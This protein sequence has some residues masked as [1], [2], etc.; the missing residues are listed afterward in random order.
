MFHF[1]LTPHHGHRGVPRMRSA[2]RE[3]VLDQVLQLWDFGVL[4]QILRRLLSQ[5]T[6][7]TRGN[8]SRFHQHG[9]FRIELMR[10]DLSVTCSITPGWDVLLSSEIGESQRKKAK[11]W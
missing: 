1:L 3:R 9:L 2:Q 5:R 7:R 6:E 4:H 8:V 10:F 11:S